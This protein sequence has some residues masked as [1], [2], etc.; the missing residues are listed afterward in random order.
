MIRLLLLIPALTACTITSPSIDEH[1][2]TLDD[3]VAVAVGYVVYNICVNYAR[4]TSIVARFS[5]PDT[6]EE[7]VIF[8]HKH[9]LEYKKMKFQM[10][11]DD[12]VQ[13]NSDTIQLYF[14]KDDDLAY[15]SFATAMYSDGH[16]LS[17]ILDY[18]ISESAEHIRLRPVHWYTYSHQNSATVA[19]HTKRF[20]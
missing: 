19:F 4:D 17:E 7:L 8:Q 15:E 20:Q 13:F 6:S 12:Y 10:M 18:C 5:K 2:P 9:E 14:P 3:Q 11:F 16:S 1:T